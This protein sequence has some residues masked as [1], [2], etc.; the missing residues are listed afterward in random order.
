M[1]DDFDSIIVEHSFNSSI[2]DVW[3][4]ITNVNEMRLWFFDN[5]NEFE[6]IVGFESRFNVNS[7]ERSFLHLWKLTGVEEFKRI[8]YNWKYE[9][10]PGDSE[11]IFELFNRNDKTLLRLTH[12]ILDPFPQ[13]I[14]EFS[15]ESGIN[16][17]NYLITQSLAEFLAKSYD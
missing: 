14:P 10:Y 3:N 8:S 15:R 7:G 13:N 5:I 12:K 11:V 2:K 16:G 4:A 17:W 6:P 1:K 9:D